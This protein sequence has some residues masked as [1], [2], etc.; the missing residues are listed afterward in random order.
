MRRSGGG[1]AARV[2]LGGDSAGGNLAAVAANQLCAGGDTKTLGALMLLYPITDHPSA[3][4]PSYTEN[5]SGYGLDAH[6]MR[7]FW[8]QRWMKKPRFSMLN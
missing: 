8:E 6:L 2:A 3:N 7:W 4:H 5:A 1:I